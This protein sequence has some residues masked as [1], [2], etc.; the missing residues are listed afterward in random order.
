MPAP[1]SVFHRLVV[2]VSCSHMRCPVGALRT[3]HLPR[4]FLR[5]HEAAA[6]VE[7]LIPS[8]S[9][10][11]LPP[12]NRSEHQGV[13]GVPSERS[14]CAAYPGFHPGLVCGAPL[15]HSER[16]TF[17]EASCT[18]TKRQRV[19]DRASIGSEQQ[20]PSRAARIVYPPPEFPCERRPRSAE[21]PKTCLR[22]RASERHAFE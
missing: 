12:Q 16:L 2:S 17:P 20:N 18:S 14:G 1:Y 6:P 3:P 5:L 13:C 22:R 10:G 15:G 9:S 4:G 7:A 11:T 8:A 21:P 19:G